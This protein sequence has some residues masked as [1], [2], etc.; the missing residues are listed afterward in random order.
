MAIVRSSV[1]ASVYRG[2]EK[3]LPYLAGWRFWGFGC[4]D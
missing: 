3:A 2:V 4:D 1:K